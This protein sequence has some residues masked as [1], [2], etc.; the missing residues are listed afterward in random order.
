M[1]SMLGAFAEFER[2]QFVAESL[3]FPTTS[4]RS[5]RYT[6][7]A[8]LS[9]IRARGRPSSRTQRSNRC[10][11]ACAGCMPKAPL[12]GKSQAGQPRT[13]FAQR[14]AHGTPLAF[15]TFYSPRYE[16][17]GSRLSC[18]GLIRALA[19]TLGRFL[20]PLE[21]R[22][23]PPRTASPDVRAIRQDLNRVQAPGCSIPRNAFSWR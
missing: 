13:A 20:L 8:R 10:S 11:G 3:T 12:T 21:W 9:V 4:A 17:D 22:V 7:A 23:R 18:L 5:A 15:A 14:V 16:R 1:L 6:A 2:A 19:A